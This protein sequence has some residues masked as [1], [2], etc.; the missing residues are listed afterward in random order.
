[1]SLI[2]TDNGGQFD[3]DEFRR[4]ARDWEFNHVTTSPYHSQ[5]NG[6]VESA[7]KIAKKVMKKAKR[8]GQDIWKAILDWRNTPTENMKSSQRLMSRRTRTL[9]P[10]AN[11]LLMPKVVDNVPDKLAQ[12]R[13][14]AK[15]YYDRGSKKLPELQ[16]GET[17][18]IKPSPSQRDKR[19]QLGTCLEQVAP[20]SYIVDV[21]GRE[22]RR[23]RKFLRTTQEQTEPEV[24]ESAELDLPDAPFQE[25]VR[26]ESA[27]YGN[28]GPEVPENPETLHLG[29]ERRTRTRVVKRPSRFNDYV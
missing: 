20:R 24:L 7:I 22:L 25:T 2:V 10:T 12:R 8:S 21:G 6:K 16:I 23:N 27:L 17:V 9:L 1:M 11:Q 5:S 13:Q 19:W 26:V 3:S 15:Y 18:R 14:K 4:F 29:P 28:P